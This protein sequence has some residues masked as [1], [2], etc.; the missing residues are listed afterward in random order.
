MYLIQADHQYG[1]H[2]RQVQTTKKLGCPCQI[3]MR[4]IVKFPKFKVIVAIVLF[5]VCF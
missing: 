4:H 3:R 5:S 1:K 2:R